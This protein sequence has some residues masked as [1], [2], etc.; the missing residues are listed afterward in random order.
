MKTSLLPSVGTGWLCAGLSSFFCCL[1]TASA[2]ERRPLSLPIDPEPIERVMAPTPNSFAPMLEKAMPSVVSVYT[3]EIVRVA[4]SRGSLEE[5][6][7]REM[8]GL[9]RRRVRG[10]EIEERKIPQGTGSGVIVR[11]DG[12]I[13]TNNHVVVD[14]TGEDADEILVRLHDGKELPAKIIGRDPKTD[15]ALIRVDSE[16][17]PALRM[18]DS[19]QIKVGD[20]VFAIGNPL[21]VGT[22]VTQGIVS[23]RDRAIGIYGSRGYESFIQT[24]AAINRGNSGGALVD[25]RGRLIGLNS[26]IVSQSGGSIGL[27]FAIPTNLL[28]SV[29]GQLAEHGEVKRGFLGVEVGEVT[30]EDAEAYGL[31]KPQGIVIE[32]IERGLA[33][34]LAGL[35]RGDVIT[36]VAGKPIRSVDE[37][38]VRVGHIVPGTPVDIEIVR[39]GKPQS[40]EVTIS[41]RAQ[42]VGG[43]GDELL[44]GIAVAPVDDELR[45]RHGIP[46]RLTGVAVTRADKDSPYARFLDPG[47][48]ILEINDER[49]RGVSGA[50]AALRRGTNRVLVYDRG[51]TGY[52]SLRLR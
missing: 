8:F 37:L 28:A 32:G 26:A 14:Q 36:M 3:A 25:T 12:Y 44:E 10:A 11:G 17:L 27:G 43:V 9:P 47:I 22:T 13:L 16:R 30:A 49:V 23:A 6:M 2:Q 35:E 50:R 19:D 48:V 51:R 29:S 46:S 31:D 41:D 5:E 52:L 4:R 42:K 21:G 18:A 24:D 1:Q 45:K 20:V 15:I 38:R 7:L 39:G 33:A 34:D 40:V